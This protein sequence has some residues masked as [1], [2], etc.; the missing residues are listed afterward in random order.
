MSDNE[1][2]RCPPKPPFAPGSLASGSATEDAAHARWEAQHGTHAN[3][4][5]EG[6]MQNPYEEMPAGHLRVEIT[7]LSALLD[8]HLED[9]RKYLPSEPEDSARDAYSAALY[10]A[11]AQ[12]MVEHL[13]YA[14]GALAAKEDAEKVDRASAVLEFLRKATHYVDGDG[15]RLLAHARDYLRDV[16]GAK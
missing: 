12:Q 13:R 4:R 11:N 14:R 16:M 2:C 6:N 15:I 3:A 9:A 5:Q 1:Q 10:V 8:S 7:R